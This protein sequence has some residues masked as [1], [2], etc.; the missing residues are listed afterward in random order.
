MACW[1]VMLD[2]LLLGLTS[3]SI[4]EIESRR[5]IGG[6]P[7]CCCLSQVLLSVVRSW[8]SVVYRGA[9]LDAR[10][11]ADARIAATERLRIDSVLAER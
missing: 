7:P 4:L 11:C 5:E 6:F 2:R 3:L 1:L 9:I 10:V 8:G